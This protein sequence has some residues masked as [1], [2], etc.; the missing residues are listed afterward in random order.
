MYIRTANAV[1]AR[2]CTFITLFV[3]QTYDILNLFVLSQVFL[4]DNLD[5]G[6]CN[7]SHNVLPRIADF[8]PESF[9]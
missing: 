2:Q 3:H 6:V 7:K 4:I 9:R 1:G 8:D 5:L